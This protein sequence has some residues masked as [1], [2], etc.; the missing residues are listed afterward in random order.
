MLK[1][2]RWLKLVLSVLLTAALQACSNHIDLHAGLTE[3]D[4]NE[5]LSALLQE[6][7]TAEKMIRKDGVAIRVPVDQSGKALKTLQAQGLPK[8]KQDGMG[9]V[10]KKENLISSPLEERA[11]YLYALSQEIE[12]T[13]T[14]M[15]GVIA[16]RVH[17][18]LPER[19]GPGEPTLPSSAAVFVKYHD[20][21]PFQIYLPKIRSLVFNS[22]P[23]L[24]GDERE[25][26]T[27][28]AVPALAKAESKVQLTWVGP[29]A[30][31]ASSAGLFKTIMIVA[32]VAW[33]LSMAGLVVWYR[34]PQLLGKSRSVSRTGDAVDNAK[35]E[36]T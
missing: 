7:I 13:L 3:A 1:S 30:V 9:E 12:K 14:T 21:I 27:I 10:F 33:L 8:R 32:L 35:H 16:A 2:N 31:E 24:N 26:I 6:G 29:I 15:D 25:K 5:V 36:N 4:G 28:V 19:L 22:I 23:G 11:R 34:Y 17:I 20:G 18:V